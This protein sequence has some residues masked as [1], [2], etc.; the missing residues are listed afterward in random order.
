MPYVF[1]PN[2]ICLHMLLKDEIINALKHS[3]YKWI[4]I[5]I[6]I[7]IYVVAKKARLMQW[8]DNFSFKNFIVQK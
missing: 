6:Y 4:N 2:Q 7:Y 5:E 3:N 1:G 8:N